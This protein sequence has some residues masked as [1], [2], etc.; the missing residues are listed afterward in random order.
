MNLPRTLILDFTTSRT[1]R[2]KCLL[3]KAMQRM[4]ICYSSVNGLSDQT[5]IKKQNKEN[6]IIHIFY[7]KLRILNR[8][9]AI[10][11]IYIHA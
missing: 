6:S 5:D 1:V 8:Q 4:M 10:A 9:V 7:I 2:N 11:K 3:F